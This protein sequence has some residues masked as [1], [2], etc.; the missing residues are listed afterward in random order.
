M[1]RSL[2]FVQNCKVLVLCPEWQVHI[3]L[4]LTLMTSWLFFDI[5]GKFFGALPNVRNY[6]ITVLLFLFF[7]FSRKMRMVVV[8]CPKWPSSL[9]VFCS[10]WPKFSVPCLPCT[11]SF[12]R[13]LFQKRYC[14]LS[15]VR[16][17]F[18]GLKSKGSMFFVLNDKTFLLFVL[19]ALN[20]TFLSKIL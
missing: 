8:L 15:V 16:N 14:F 18:L 9:F 4:S 13:V 6:K 1:T 10:I 2:F 12:C 11:E 5:N 17:D 19:N 20:L 7:F 3:F